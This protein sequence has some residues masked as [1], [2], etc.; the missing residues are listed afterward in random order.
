MKRIKK[1]SDACNKC[2]FPTMVAT[3]KNG[4]MVMKM[5]LVIIEIHLECS[6]AY[7]NENKII[8]VIEKHLQYDVAY[9]SGDPATAIK[10]AFSFQ[11]N[12]RCWYYLL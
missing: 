7:K 5:R 8:L 3:Y 11:S 12:R 1:N 10:V 2:H 9:K 4:E 6:V